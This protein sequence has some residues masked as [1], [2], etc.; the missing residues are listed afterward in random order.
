MLQATN[1]R[2]PDPDEV[3]IFFSIRLILP[4]ALGPGLTQPLT[5][6]NAKHK[7]KKFLGNRTRPTCNISQPYRPSQPVT[8]TALL[9]HTQKESVNISR[10]GMNLFPQ[11]VKCCSNF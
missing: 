7:N 2:V 9:L 6:M 11:I 8:G 3:I 1:L 4:V 10:Y 5:E